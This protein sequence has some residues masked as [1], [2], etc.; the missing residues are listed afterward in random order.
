[1]RPP[2]PNPLPVVPP[3]RISTLLATV[4]FFL[5]STMAALLLFWLSR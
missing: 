5:L 1:M 4:L 3:S 2:V